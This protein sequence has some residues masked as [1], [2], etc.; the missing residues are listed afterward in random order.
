MA[1]NSLDVEVR[2][3]LQKRRGDWAAIAKSAEVS[4]SWLSKF[5]RGEIPN[6]GYTTLKR[7]RDSLLAKKT[8][9]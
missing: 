8:T 1:E 4:H 6:P 9:A 7:V 5:F 3:L 2:T